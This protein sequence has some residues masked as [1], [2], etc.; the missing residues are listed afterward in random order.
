MV[1]AS[2]RAMN[3]I[4]EVQYLVRPTID[5]ASRWSLRG[6][7]RFSIVQ[8]LLMCLRQCFGH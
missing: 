2:V 7:Y 6:F 5:V 4:S 3:Y 1:E 8:L